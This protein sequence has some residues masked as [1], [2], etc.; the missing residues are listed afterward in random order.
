MNIRCQPE[1]A[2][3]VGRA[4]GGEALRYEGGATLRAAKGTSFGRPQNRLCFSLGTATNLL[5]CVLTL[6]SAKGRWK[7]ERKASQG[8]LGSPIDVSAIS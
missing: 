5:Q 2:L 8:A 6:H 7:L 3:E 1:Q 4:V